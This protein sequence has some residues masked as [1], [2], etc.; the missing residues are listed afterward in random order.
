MFGYGRAELVGQPVEILLPERFRARHVAS[1][2]GYFE[3][4]RLRPMGAS[5]ELSGR[6]KDGSE[7]P[8]DIM[9]NPMPTPDGPAALSVIRDVTDRKL[10][11]AALKASETRFRGLVEGIAD[12]AVL[13]LDPEGAVVSQ[14]GAAERI[15][16]TRA[17]E[18]L[19][20]PVALLEG[21]DPERAAAAL[22]RAA[23]EGRAEEEGWRLRRDGTRYWAHSVLTALRDASG[24]LVGFA[25]VT[26]D[27]TESRQAA[28]ELRRL[29][30][31]LE[32]QVGRHTA[33]L[34]EANR[35]LLDEIDRRKRSEELRRKLE[36]QLQH[37]QKM[38][39]LGRLAGGIAHDFNNLLTGMMAFSELLIEHLPADDP[40]REGAEEAR[41]SCERSALLT[42]QLLAVSRRQV[43]DPVVLDLSDTIAD[44][45]R[46]LGR[47][48][49]EDIELVTRLDPSLRNIKADPGKVEQ[50]VLNLAVNAR[51]AMPAGGRLTIET[52]N[53]DVDADYA[54][55]HSGMEAGAYVMLAVSDTGVGMDA[56]TLG[57]I[58][59]PFFTTKERGKGTGL[60]LSTVYGIVKQSGASI[61]VY[62]EPGQGATFKIYFPAV[63]EALSSAERG[64]PEETGV[65]GGSERVLVVEDDA[66]V[67]LTVCR[68][69]RG[70]GY[71]VRDAASG[72]EALATLGA[73]SREIDLLLS[74]VV[75]PQMSG[76]DLAREVV[77]ARPGVRVLYMSAHMDDALVHRGVLDAQSA[78]LEK[79]FTR[80]QL[81]GK[82]RK[83]LD[84]R[85]AAS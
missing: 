7:F 55:Q 58:F 43:L 81:L 38:E 49:G 66:A 60:G 17:G 57:H 85:P 78:F 20:R 65:A 44:M 47:L 59:E 21:G 80:A 42:R 4:P 40:L 13:V 8:V 84:A 61:W 24:S 67:R 10:V 16:G 18:V 46:M 70:H 33:E 31:G 52:A 30:D 77:A 68:I 32:Q 79:P 28:E 50:V 53:V 45:S 15:H 51:D 12:Y 19:G 3:A 62:S 22:S 73:D 36:E 41:R 74:D 11:E 23:A 25:L 63:A 83:V 34:A 35:T 9:L 56:E 69:L 6:R 37:S 29:H 14:S 26:R 48:I 39:A 75:M 2:Q 82:V 27:L 76:P 64:G 72:P 54:A 5:L 1:R 71:E